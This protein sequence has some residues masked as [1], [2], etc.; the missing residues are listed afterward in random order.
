M[1]EFENKYK[2]LG[3]KTILGLD[4]AGRG[5]LAGPVVIA[6]VILNEGFYNEEINDSKKLTEKTRERLYPIIIENSKYQIE[7]ISNEEID[8]SNIY[9]VCQNAMIKIANILKP[10]FTLSDAMPLN[11]EIPHEAIIKGD[12][13]SLSIASASILAKVT[14]DKI[15]KD[16]S[17]LYPL[18]NFKQNKGYGTKEHFQALNKYGP[19][20]IHRLSFEPLKSLLKE[21]RFF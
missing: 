2:S 5:P 10:D 17:L 9:K 11:N 4:E 12:S 16:Y 20:P 1:L 6:G 8:K 19:C 15:M 3:Y 18:Y 7:I 13:K 21:I 14:R